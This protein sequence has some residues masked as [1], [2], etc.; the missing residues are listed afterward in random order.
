[1][2]IAEAIAQA[3]QSVPNTLEQK[4]K[5]DWLNRLDW[6]VQTEVIQ[7]YVDAE[8]FGGYT[9]S[10]A[11]STS[12]LVPKPYDEMYIRYLEAMI[13]RYFGENSKYNNCIAEFN[14]IYRRFQAQYNREH[15]PKGP[16]RYTY[17]GGE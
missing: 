2:T 8:E 6:Q 5:L 9:E 7:N 14:S 3:N 11:T 1:M 17:F 15:M 12:L 10:T 4:I 16:Y 13:Y